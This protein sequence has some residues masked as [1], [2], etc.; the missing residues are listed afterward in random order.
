MAEPDTDSV[1]D[2]DLFLIEISDGDQPRY[3]LTERF[4]TIDPGR[5]VM[6]V[7]WAELATLFRGRTLRAVPLPGRWSGRHGSTRRD[8][9]NSTDPGEPGLS[10]DGGPNVQINI[11][12]AQR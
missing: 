7:P 10:T 1:A 5:D 11:G 12:G 6:G 9:V 3:I 8:I 4:L 2:H